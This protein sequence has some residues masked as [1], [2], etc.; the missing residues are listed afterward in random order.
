MKRYRL[1]AVVIVAVICCALCACTPKPVKSN[2]TSLTVSTVCGATVTE[3]TATLTTAQY[4]ALTSAED[5]ATQCGYIL[6]EKATL[7]VALA[8][9]TLTFTVTAE[10]GTTRSES[11]ALTVL[12]GD[13]SL[14]VST[15][16]GATVTEGTATLTTA[17]YEALTAAEDK[18]TQCGYILAEKA[19]LAVALAEK[20]LTF[21][22]T[23]E[24][25]TTRSESIALTVLSGDTSL[26]VSTVCGAT[27]T[28]GTATLTTAQY[29][30]LTAAE[31]KATQCGY[32]LAEKATLAV[33][34][35]EKML[36]F[37]VTAEDGTTRSES[38][39]LTV[40]SGD[41]TLRVS[42]LFGIDVK[43]GAVVMT[44]GQF[45]AWLEETD[46]LGACEYTAAEASAVT[47]Q[48]D[49]AA[50]T[51]IVR[52]VS[53]D[54]TTENEVAVRIEA[55]RPFGAHSA[56]AGIGSRDNVSYDYGNKHFVLNGIAAVTTESGVNLSGQW[57]L[58]AEFSVDGLANGVELGILAYAR[59]NL[60]VRFMVSGVDATH[61]KLYTDYYDRSGAFLGRVVL[62]ES[63]EQTAGSFVKLGM[64]VDGDSVIM[65][66]DGATMYR[67]T[68]PSLFDAECV[69]ATVDC[70][71]FVR[72]VKVK[73]EKAEVE[74]LYADALVGYTDKNVGAV[75]VGST[76]G[77]SS[78][79]QNAD[80]SVTVLGS[81][82]STRHI[83]G[84]YQEGTPVA[85]Y[86][87]AVSG[88]VDTVNAWVANSAGKLEFMV[89]SSTTLFTKI[90]VLRY[91]SVSGKAAINSVWVYNAINGPQAS[92]PIK[93]VDNLMTDSKKAVNP[94]SFEY[95]FV[96]D[97]AVVEMYIKEGTGS[98]HYENW[99]KVYELEA[100]TWGYTAFAFGVR[101]YMDATFANTKAY[102]NDEFDTFVGMLRN[103]QSTV[104][105]SGYADSY[106]PS[107]AF[108]KDGNGTFNKTDVPYGIA[109]LYDGESKVKGDSWIVSGALTMQTY[110]EFGQAELSIVKDE[111]HAI[112]YVYEYVANGFQVFTEY[113][114]GSAEWKF[115][116][117]VQSPTAK[118]P[119]LL[120]FTVVN[121]DGVVSFLI[122]GKVWHS[123][124]WSEELNMKAASFAIGGKGSAFKTSNLTVLTESTEV[125]AFAAQMEKQAYVSTFTN[126][127]AAHEA[128]YK[129]A[130]PGGTML[131]GASTLDFWET[132]AKD[133]GLTDG[134]TG[135]NVGIGSTKIEDWTYAYDTLVKPLAPSK[136]LIYLG[137]NNILQGYSSKET[138]ALLKDFLN[139]LHTDFPSAQ[140]YV[141]ELISCPYFYSNG[142]FHTE[143]AR[144]N[145]EIKAF[146]EQNQSWLT[147]ISTH[148]ALTEDGN[149]VESYFKADKLHLT[150]AGYAAFCSVIKPIMFPNN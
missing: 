79:T 1:M 73:T 141:L 99:T 47:A 75:P 16:C 40:L 102:Y 108:Q 77:L 13:T 24:D 147:A 135:Y 14:T 81:G 124:E 68:L 74:K 130:T 59:R 129:T 18:A 106:I 120:N 80:G 144:Y 30:A 121:D 7:A 32:I 76:Q 86:R 48:Y 27:V 45:G 149:A 61:F 44:E 70:K 95:A 146:C 119:G 37:T 116:R 34:L 71:A 69:L 66:H 87:Y 127:I 22:V 52:C 55:L 49:A 63:V 115:W 88:R 78:F 122:N 8:E 109:Y 43:D 138:I 104:A 89:L 96:Y 85:G 19:T 150:E 54:E 28:E 83:V 137:A 140:L 123:Y 46:V 67:R 134:V 94:Y 112:R 113:K 21:T 132:Y 101:Q 12:S 126:Q 5:K 2:D 29:E 143:Y 90:H 82:K 57:A 136:V 39:A 23:A 20:T 118:T 105:L 64:I 148:D 72:G 100:S 60:R 111:T 84:V 58:E 41:A 56:V 114:H 11:I 42:K 15:V 107:V 33:V 128:T 145:Q 103:S 98:A 65:T 9:K 92:T 4:E 35:A 133:L 26:T 131:L 31:D 91:P 142:V 17:Q 38:I 50:H 51:V 139:K 62:A 97:G 117:S 36:T 6:A 3:G 110:Q 53:E 125:R 93:A 10:D 25:G